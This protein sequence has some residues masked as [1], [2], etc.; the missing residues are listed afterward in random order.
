MKDVDNLR[1]GIL[2]GQEIKLMLDNESLAS[3][4]RSN[5]CC[6]IGKVLTQ[7]SLNEVTQQIIESI[8]YFLN[9]KGD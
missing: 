1:N 7:E 6:H 5:L 8:T 3:L 4:L 9:K 2:M